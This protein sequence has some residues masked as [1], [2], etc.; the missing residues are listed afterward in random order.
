M[1][2]GQTFIF[3]VRDKIKSEPRITQEKVYVTTYEL[4][5]IFYLDFLISAEKDKK[6]PN[7]ELLKT[8][9]T[10]LYKLSFNKEKHEIFSDDSVIFKCLGK[11]VE[12][13]EGWYNLKVKI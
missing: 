8:Y 4:K 7:K 13:K 6:K 2:S 9:K 12:T 3:T 1:T 11:F 5:L 10:E